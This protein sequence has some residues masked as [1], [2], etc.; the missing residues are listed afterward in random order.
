MT[1]AQTL[2]MENEDKE[3]IAFVNLPSLSQVRSP[4]QKPQT[5]GIIVCGLL[6]PRRL[7]VRG[8]APA[9]GRSTSGL[10]IGKSRK[11]ESCPRHVEAAVES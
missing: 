10:A 11:K 8:P 7:V 5:R 4:I 2:K 9:E 6:T 3:G 1:T